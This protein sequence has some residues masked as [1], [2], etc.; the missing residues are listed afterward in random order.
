ICDSSSRRVRE[1]YT[2]GSRRPSMSRLTPFSTSTR[3]P[4]TLVAGASGGDDERGEGRADVIVREL[5]PAHGLPRRL[6]EHETRPP[7]F[8]LL[9][10]TERGPRALEVDPHRLR[11]QHRLDVVG[12]RA[13]EPKMLDGQPQRRR[14]AERD[15][16]AVRHLLVAGSRL[17]SVR[18][19]VTQVEHAPL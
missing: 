16:L 10:A 7:P 11:S 8:R 5:D 17:E 4:L 18:E 9:V 2:A 19:R 15:R 3:T 6:E 1:P 14:Q 12:D 13:V